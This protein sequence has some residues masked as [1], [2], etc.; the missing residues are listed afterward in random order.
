MKYLFAILQV[1]YFPVPSNRQFAE[2]PVE[3]G[4]EKRVANFIADIRKQY[5][6]KRR[7]VAQR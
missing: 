4:R 5:A 6:E 1:V 3:N 7:I 2:M